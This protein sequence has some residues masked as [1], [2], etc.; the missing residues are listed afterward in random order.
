MNETHLAGL[1]LNRTDT[2]LPGRSARIPTILVG[3]A[4]AAS[5]LVASACSRTRTDPAKVYRI[6]YGGDRP[7]H[8]R[9]DDG[10]PT[11]LAVSMVQE[12]A[13]RRGIRLEWVQAAMA[14]EDLR[15]SRLDLFVLLTN[16]PE[17]RNL[18]HLTTPYL[19]TETAFLVPEK[20]RFHTLA[21]LAAARIAFNN[22]EVHRLAVAH[23]LPDSVRTPLGSTTDA[24]AAIH[25][26]M[27]DAA[28]VDQYAGVIGLLDGAANEPLRIIP[29]GMPIR[30]LSLASTFESQGTAD[31]IR[32]EIARLSENEELTPVLARWSM[33]PVLMSESVDA[34]NQERIKV[35]ALGWG[36]VVLATLILVFAG[37]VWRLRQRNGL[38]A[39]SE[40]R[41]R[42]LAETA[43][44]GVMIHDGVRIV[45]ANAQFAKLFGYDSPEELMGA[46]GRPTILTD[47]SVVKLRD[48]ISGG[49][50]LQPLEIV[51]VRKDGSHFDI[52]TQGCNSTYRGRKARVVAMRDI[53]ERKRA[54][55][56]RS[57]LEADLAQA[58]KMET[59]GRLA[60]GIAH[61]FNNLLT[62][63]IGY[64]SLILNDPDVKGRSRNRVSSIQKAGERAAELTGQLLAFSR[65]QVI[66]PCPLD[67]NALVQETRSLMARLIPANI[68]VVSFLGQGLPMVMAD[69]GQMHQVVVNLLLNARDAMPEGGRL[70][71]ETGAVTL[72]ASYAEQHPEAVVP[73]QY[74]LLAVTDN[75]IGMAPDVAARIFEPFFTTK[76]TGAGTG[77]GLATVYGIVRQSGG[78]IWVYSEIGKGST[79]K[80]YLPVAEA[81]ESVADNTESIPFRAGTAT[82]LVVDDQENVRELIRE[83]LESHGYGVLA[84]ANGAEALALVQASARRIDLL[85][86]DV[87]MPGMS[88]KE[89]AGQLQRET[90]GLKV[91]FMSGYTEN[92]IVNRGILKP[93]VEFLPKPLTP[94]SI[95][96]N[97][98]RVLGA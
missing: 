19:A 39:E 31:E 27:A 28:Y 38:L 72:D 9:G 14:M 97:V 83:I 45:E 11:G 26:G 59:V 65:R 78:W 91:L 56:V 79:F 80:V 42:T 21:E 40:S 71:L 93:G 18:V 96:S 41:F 76:P 30:Q 25:K 92:V 55:E 94:D 20:S 46:N 57:K 95:I 3:L 81:V 53:S 13:R 63:I 85:L 60:G 24:I 36:A 87:V 62:V 8:Y 17:R 50:N 68:E 34:L 10:K 16:L 70:V 61:D 29:S 5:I 73:G 35:R 67:F 12:A 90:P 58:Q 4:L 49:T 47:E 43:F 32:D 7:L 33:F 54:A 44:E 2:D 75:G 48:R 22:L 64:C 37:L 88:G 86:T 66:K 69:A 82:I 89:L 84:A 98:G 6:G 77:L 15:S 52:E 1:E 51:G 74:V 23:L